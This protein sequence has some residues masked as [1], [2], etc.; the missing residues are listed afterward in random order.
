MPRPE[1]PRPTRRG[2]LLGLAGAGGVAACQPRVQGPGVLPPSFAGPRL[3][4]D[5]LVA[6]GRRAPAP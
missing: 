6:A 2:A 3:E 1:A 5:S 4:P